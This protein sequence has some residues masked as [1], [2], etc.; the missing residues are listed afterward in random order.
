MGHKIH[1]TGLRLG[2]TQEHRSRWFADSNRYPELLQE[3]DQIRR[4]LTKTL[5]NAGLAG[6]RIERKADQIELEIRTA[7]PGVV[8]GRGGAGI[9]TLREGLQKEIKTDRQ[10]RVNVVEVDK[11]DAEAALIAEYI[12]QQLER[13]VS[14]RRVVRQAMQRAQR[15]GVKGIKVQV[16]GRLNGA[17]IARTECI[18]KAGCRCIHCVQISIMQPTRRQRHTASSV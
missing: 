18:A 14:F 11:V 3:D 15:A 6:I 8:V 13:R 4:Y 9:E 17:E 10:I 1:P 2:I 16:G 7:R 5:A 12:G